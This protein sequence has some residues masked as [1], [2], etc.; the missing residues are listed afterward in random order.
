M[1]GKIYFFSSFFISTQHFNITAW[2]NEK[3]DIFKDNANYSCISTNNS[4]GTGVRSTTF[5]GVECKC[6]V[7]SFLSNEFIYF[8]RAFKLSRILYT[9]LFNIVKLVFDFDSF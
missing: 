7:F 2:P 1:L 5:F 3:L 8:L 9:V 4:V 6:A